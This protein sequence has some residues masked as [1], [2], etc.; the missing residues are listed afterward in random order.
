V[1]VTVVWGATFVMVKEAVAAYP[2]FAFLALRFALAFL[3]L[4]PLWFVVRRRQGKHDIQGGRNR[5]WAR[6][7]LIGIFLFASFAFQ[8]AGLQYTT[9]SRAGF[10]TGLSVVLVPLFSA[11]VLR[12]LPNP[13][14]LLG[15]AL[16]TVGMLLLSW[17]GGGWHIGKGELLVLAC[18]FSIAA[19]ITAVGAFAPGGDVLSLTTVQI[20]TVCV[21]SGLASAAFEH[22]ASLPSLAVWGTAAFTGVFAT[23]MAFGLQTAAQRFTTPTHTALIF[24]AEPVFAAAFG[25]LLAGERLGRREVL[26]CGLILLGMLTA[27]LVPI[28]LGKQRNPKHQLEE[29]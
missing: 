9:A 3:A 14:A 6:G 26:G 28:V 10:I 12:R 4:L 1:L 24:A 8:T 20:A 16:A 19:H 5:N 22:P 15:V 17:G 29:R 11:V 18:A 25:F 2:V 23:S 13:W 27:E 21:L 7:A